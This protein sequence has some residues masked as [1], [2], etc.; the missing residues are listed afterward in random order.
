MKIRTLSRFT[1]LILVYLSIGSSSL[2]GQNGY[3]KNLGQFVNQNGVENEEVE[4]LFRSYDL[5]IQLRQTGFSYDLFE[6]LEKSSDNSGVEFHKKPTQPVRINRVDVD[7]I[8]PSSNVEILQGGELTSK[9]NYYLEQGIIENAPTVKSVIYENLY[10]GVDLEFTSTNRGIPKYNFHVDRPSD[11]NNVLIQYSGHD[12]IKVTDYEVVM[13]TPL[14]EIHDTIPLSFF[15]N[16]TQQIEADVRYVNHGNGLIGLELK[17]CEEDGPLTVDPFPDVIWSTYVGNGLDYGYSTCFSPQLDVYYG[18]SSW[19]SGM[20]TDGAHDTTVEYREDALIRKFDEDGVLQWSTYYGGISA[21]AAVDIECDSDGNVY[22]TGWFGPGTYGSTAGSYQEAF[23]GG[24]SDAILV[25]LDSDGTRLFGTYYGGGGYDEAYSLVIHNDDEIYIMGYTASGSNASAIASPGAYKTYMSG[26]S[27]SFVAKFDSD[28]NRIWGTYFGGNSHET[29]AVKCG[30]DVNSNG[31]VLIAGYTASS[32]GIAT[33][34]AHNSTS[35]GGEDGFIAKLNSSGELLWATFTGGPADDNITGAVFD[36]NGDIFVCGYTYSTTGIASTNGYDTSAAGGGDSFVQKFDSDGNFLSGTYLGG[37]SLDIGLDID[38]YCNEVVVYGQTRSFNFPATPG[39]Y[40]TSL[41]GNWDYT[42]TMLDQNLEN[43]VWSSY[44]GGMNN[45]SQDYYI[46]GIA[47]SAEFGGAEFAFAGT[48]TSPDYIA[49]GDADND[50]KVGTLSGFLT[51]FS[52]GEAADLISSDYDEICSG[53]TLELTAP[54]GYESYLW[55]N[56]LGT[57]DTIHVSPTSDSFYSLEAIAPG[58]CKYSDLIQIDVEPISNVG[59]NLSK[60]TLCLG[61][62]FEINATGTDPYTWN[63]GISDGDIITPSSIGEH[64]YSL[65]GTKVS[66]GCTNLVTASVTVSAL[67]NV[68]ATA[69]EEEICF[70][71]STQLNGSGADVY[72]WDSGVVNGQDF[73]PSVGSST[74]EV[75]GVNSTSGCENT[76]SIEIVVNELPAVTASVSD[77][78]ICLGEAA[79][80]TGGGADVYSWNGGVLNGEEIL[81]NTAGSQTFEVTGTNST[82]ACTNTATI[83]VEIHELP[84]VEATVSDDEIC[85]G[86][87]IIFSGNGA[88]SYTWNSGIDNGLSF[89]PSNTGV[90]TGTVTGVDSDS[91]CENSD[92]VDLTVLSLP[93][94]GASASEEEICDGETIELSGSGADTYTWD[95]GIVDGLSFTPEVGSNTYQVT[96]LNSSSGCEN[97]A[98]I[99]IQVNSLPAV[100]ASVSDSEICQGESVIFQGNGA[101]EYS[102]NGEVINAQE[103]SLITAGSLTFEVTGTST[104][105]SCS[106]TASVDVEVHELPEVDALASSNAICLGETLIFNGSGATSYTWDLGIENGV[107]FEPS[108]TGSFLATVEGTDS[109]TGCTN[110]DSIRIEVVTLPDV[111]AISSD[112]EI[113]EGD[114]IV[115]FGSGAESFTWDQGVLDNTYFHPSTGNHTYTV[116]GSNGSEF[117][118]NSASVQVTVY[119]LPNVEATVSNSEICFGDSVIF[120]GSGAHTYEWSNGVV[121]GLQF[122]P[123]ETGDLEFSVTGV[124]V[125]TRCQNQVFVEVLVNSL[126]DV[127]ATASPNPVCAGDSFEINGMGADSYIWENGHMNGESISVNNVGSYSYSVIGTDSET[128]CTAVD[129]I[130]VVVEDPPEVSIIASA[131]EICSGESITLTGAGASEYIWSLG[132]VDGEEF[133]P[134]LGQTN[135]TLIGRIGNENCQDTASISIV[136]NDLPPVNGGENQTLCLNKE[137]SLTLENAESYQSYSWS[138]GVENGEPFSIS[139]SGTFTFSV[140]AIDFNNCSNSDQVLVYINNCDTLVILPTGLSPNE[141]GLNDL[142]EFSGLAGNQ[143]SLTVFSEWGD[144]VY[145][146]SDYKNDWGGINYLGSSF[147]KNRKLPTGTYYYILLIGEDIY[148]NYIYISY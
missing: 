88:D 52:V 82:T 72:T 47:C 20:A 65:T 111:Q 24:A 97:T 28:G 66:S 129:S 128:N 107:P 25:K 127:E 5:N 142:L 119:E 22:F 56:G 8:N 79:V 46:A 60:S 6:K 29:S 100:T 40:K 123:Q 43:A 118:Q 59:I 16:L 74:Y 2:N 11:L 85:L 96:G 84:N 73:S 37:S 35:Q 136:V 69:S 27:D 67:P 113:C 140:T 30:I 147:E 124:D 68:G 34:G 39:A 12:S 3:E 62:S 13:Y 80:F 70:G 41:T 143:A 63:D 45:D 83:D 122:T 77:S 91:G 15:N 106:N 137:L 44:F 105:N 101:N 145:E 51:V 23:G 26:S 57:N 144:K 76:A 116:I 134:P 1:L 81:M 14:A 103:I 21:E 94:V 58:G 95:S 133:S 49:Y 138:D 17:S 61:E 130:I 71:E 89:E 4:Y 38:N 64:T 115:V 9:T 139:D 114:S 146:N 117:C 54:E 7:F 112:I 33:A 110:I 120:T 87:S 126:P 90:M 108:S 86:E 75:T 42:V 125:V 102:W 98:T 93:N 48:T 18:G 109:A 99:D 36:A 141:D 31:D 92:S 132:V 32:S 10:N 148:R 131:E 135:Y 78:D 121:D 19:S 55:G 50:T 104:S 53:E